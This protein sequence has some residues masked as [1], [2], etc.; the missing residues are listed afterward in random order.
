MEKYLEFLK[1]HPELSYAQAAR[2]LGVSRQF[3]CQICKKYNIL[4]TKRA[5]G[6]AKPIIK[7]DDRK[8]G[9]SLYVIGEHDCGPVKIGIANDIFP[10]F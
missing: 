5:L 6:G 2:E 3:V 9:A 1:L 8:G 4:L 10:S 7:W